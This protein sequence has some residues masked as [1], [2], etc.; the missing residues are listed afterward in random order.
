MSSGLE[1]GTIGTV[2]RL[3]VGTSTDSYHLQGQRSSVA[4]AIHEFSI[5][6]LQLASNL[7]ITGLLCIAA[8]NLK[9]L[10]AIYMFM[11]KDFVLHCGAVIPK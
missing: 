7:I 1:I 4:N 9:T 2:N 11:I 10:K 6:D 5:R 8:V 3:T